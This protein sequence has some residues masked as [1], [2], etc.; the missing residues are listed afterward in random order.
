MA[1][2]AMELGLEDKELLFELK[3][4]D[5]KNQAKYIHNIVGNHK[6]IMVTA[7]SHMLRSMTLFKKMG[8]D[9]YQHQ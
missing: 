3:S 1:E 6:F 8:C 5:T 9:L 2:V 7:A 4:N